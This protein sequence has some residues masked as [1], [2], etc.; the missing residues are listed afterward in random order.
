MIAYAPTGAA[1]PA[2]KTAT[3]KQIAFCRRLAAERGIEFLTDGT[4]I[5][6]DLA[7]QA[8]DR[9]VISDQIDLLMK[10]PRPVAPTPA[11]VDGPIDGLDLTTLYGGRYAATIDGV[12]KFFK[13]DKA[14]EGKWAGWVFVKIQASDDLH[15]QGSQKPGAAY[16]GASEDYLRA[17]VANEEAAFALYGHELGACG[18]CGRTLTDEVSRE[19]GIGPV[20]AD[21]VGF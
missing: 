8:L 19:R 15:R 17:I 4:D 3:D 12:T 2:R 18:V 1:R 14:T 7:M 20:C 5:T 16:K 10:A 11:P 9:F 13:I 21:R 6:D